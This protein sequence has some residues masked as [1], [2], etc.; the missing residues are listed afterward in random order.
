ME[1]YLVRHTSVNME[2]G[3]CY[4]KSDIDV[5]CAFPAE[6]EVIKNKL[7]NPGSFVFY[8]SPLKRCVK[9]AQKLSSSD[10]IPDNR[11]IEC[12]FGEWELKK[13]ASLEGEYF[14]KWQGDYVNM[15][16]PN[17]ETYLEIYERSSEFFEE[18]IKKA[19]PKTA[20]IT[21]GGVIRAILAYVLKI[22]L[23]RVFS[24]SID[25]CS[26]SVISINGSITEVKFINK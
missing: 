11:L 5:S 12:N 15:P 2:S 21:H 16:C 26:V 19:H 1:I 22:P 17:G 9:L 25:C 6:L 13:W 18:L 23:D 3:T 10:F 24:I 14:K 4:G 8:T 20:V 7:G